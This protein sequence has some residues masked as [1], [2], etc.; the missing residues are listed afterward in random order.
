MPSREEHLSPQPWQWTRPRVL[1][2][3]ADASRADARAAELRR[4]G[5][6]VAICPGPSADDACPLAA[7]EGCAAVEGADAVVSSL[8][9]DTE[10]AREALAA[11]RTRAAHVPLVVAADDT[12][13]ERL[14]AYVATMIGGDDDAA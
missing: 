14:A 13:P 6:A 12:S 7:D 2:E 3:D 5:Y 9:F 1:I 8:G 4:R 11:V 10:E